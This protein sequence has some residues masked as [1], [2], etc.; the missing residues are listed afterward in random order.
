MPPNRVTVLLG[1]QHDPVPESAQHVPVHRTS[2]LGQWQLRS[3]RERVLSCT[4]NVPLDSKRIRTS[5]W[6]CVILPTNLRPADQLIP[7]SRPNRSLLSIHLSQLRGD[8]QQSVTHRFRISQ[9]QHPKQVSK[10]TIQIPDE[11]I[12][13]LR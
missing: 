13:Y 3:V 5:S 6:H 10:C 1:V 11:L 8:L 4:P 12:I 7:F 9:I 2:Q